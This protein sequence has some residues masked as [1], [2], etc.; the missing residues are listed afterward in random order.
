MQYKHT[1]IVQ[2]PLEKVAEFHRASASMAAITPPPVIVRLHQTPEV[3]AEGDDMRFTLW[4]G[5]L[6]LH[7]WAK[8]FDVSESGF[9]DKQIEGPFEEWQHQH[10]FKSLSPQQ[11]MVMDHVQAEPKEHWFWKGFGRLMWWNLPI[12]FAFRGWK[13]RRLLAS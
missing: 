5:P 12:L 2:A 8:I 10:L 11:T 7:W 6:P 3:L 9:T 13:T 4:L 1:F